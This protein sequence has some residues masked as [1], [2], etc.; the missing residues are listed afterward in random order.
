MAKRTSAPKLQSWLATGGGQDLWDDLA[1]AYG[2]KSLLAGHTGSSPVLWSKSPITAPED[3]NGLHVV[4]RGLD[5]DVIRALGAIPVTADESALEAALIAP[6]TSAAIWGSPIHASA[7]G[8]P[9]RFPFGL[10]G[11]LGKS[12]GALAV[13]IDL[14][15]WE[16]FSFAEQFAITTAISAEF[17]AGLADT[18]ST[19]AAVE[20]AIALRDGATITIPNAVFTAAV[21]RIAAAV[22]AHAATYDAVAARIDR[23]YRAFRRAMNPDGINV[24]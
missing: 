24:S 13:K 10:A 6:A 14:A 11:A 17:R 3:L 1:A 22:V 7:A 2:F 15:T 8:I 18:E 9:A 5:R 21:S 19:R 20:Q 4:A 12:G 23:S 16:N